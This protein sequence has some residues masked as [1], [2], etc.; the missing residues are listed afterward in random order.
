MTAKTIHRSATRELQMLVEQAR[1]D[2]LIEGVEIGVA[3]A[4]DF[5]DRE[6]STEAAARLRTVKIVTVE[7]Q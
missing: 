3:L 7:Q 4:A 1:D 6:G 5:L 2:A